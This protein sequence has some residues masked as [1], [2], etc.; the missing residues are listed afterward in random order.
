[1]Q[2]NCGGILLL[3]MNKYSIS[4]IASL[5]LMLLFSCGK[6]TNN[7]NNT[8]VSVNLDNVKAIS[9]SVVQDVTYIPLET[10]DS[11]LIGRISK[12]IYRN[13]KFYIF[14]KEQNNNVT[15]FDKEGNYLFSVNKYGE[16]PGQYIEPMDMDVDEAGNIY[17]FDNT[18][19]R[20]LKFV[21]NSSDAVDILPI[22]EYFSDFAYINSDLFLLS[23]VYGLN[24]IKAKLFVYS[25]SEKK[26]K[27]LLESTFADVDDI[28]VMRASKHYFYRSGNS[29][30]YYK[31]FSSELYTI[32]KDASVDVL[33]N[34][35]SDKFA[36][37]DIL[38]KME[39]NPKEFIQNMTHIKDITS[40][41]E[42]GDYIICMPYIKPSAD[43]LLIPKSNPQKAFYFSLM[44][45]KRLS[46]SSTI[47]AVADNSL[48]C[49]M[50]YSDKG[51]AAHKDIPELKG[52]N[53]GSN[54]V[55]VLFTL[56][57]NQ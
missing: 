24:G 50:N 56:K 29:L 46:W 22:G 12:I 8:T 38:K 42:V 33:L 54:P 16:A 9:G 20:I 31:R 47:E 15:V 3:N 18:N 30:N 43:Y 21:E 52:W 34:I 27:P 48:V 40:V 44:D 19:Q 11:C 36:P 4:F 57:D 2:L 49:V 6:K 45:D 25:V 7:E 32:G 28:S 10:T 37:P 53:D 14:D 23:D 35:V 51:F 13:G 17:I 5:I 41:Y 55:L 26:N 1:M 39:K